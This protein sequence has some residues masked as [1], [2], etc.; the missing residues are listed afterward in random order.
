MEDIEKSLLL[1]IEKKII[2]NRMILYIHSENQ[3]LTLFDELSPA[4]FTNYHGFLWVCWF[5]AKDLAFHYPDS[6]FKDKYIFEF[7]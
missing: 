4:E 5:L 3:I 6:L 2:K 7:D 1:L